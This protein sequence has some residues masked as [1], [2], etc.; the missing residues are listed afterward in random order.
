MPLL[1]ILGLFLPRLVSA[2]LYFFTSWFAGVFQT[3]YWPLLGFLFMPY[4]MLWYSVVHNWYGG[5]WLTW[6]IIVL[7]IAVVVDLSSDSRSRGK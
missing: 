7:V 5:T 6:H 4:T 3:W 2:V 1:L